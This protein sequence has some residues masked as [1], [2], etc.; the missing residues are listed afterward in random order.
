MRRVYK[1]P[2]NM[3]SKQTLLLPEG[4]KILNVKTKGEIVMLYALVDPDRKV[5]ERTIILDGT[6]Y[7]IPIGDDTH[8]TYIGTVMLY[9]GVLVLHCFEVKEAAK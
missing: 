8:Y 7:A 6:G 1:Y 5:E 2:L 3:S 4:A 9:D